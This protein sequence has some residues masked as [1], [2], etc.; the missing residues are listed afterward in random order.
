[1]KISVTAKAQ[2][3]ISEI[4]KKKKLESPVIRI[5]VEGFG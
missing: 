5:F 3:K 1:M 2:E 4:A